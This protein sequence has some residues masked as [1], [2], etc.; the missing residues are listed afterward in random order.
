[1]G[2][3]R[4]LRQSNRLRV[5]R[6]DKCWTQ[7]DVANMMGLPTKFRYWQ[8]ENEAV[9]PTKKEVKQLARLFDCDAADLG[10]VVKA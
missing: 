9:Y 2:R 4:Q 6:A 7:T 3:T 5:L 8:I 10:L 1:M